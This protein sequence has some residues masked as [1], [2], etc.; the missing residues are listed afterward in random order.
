MKKTQLII[1]IFCI[2]AIL[3]M[4]ILLFRAHHNACD[5]K[6]SINGNISIAYINSDTLW[7]KYEFAKKYT[8]E[9]DTLEANLQ[10]TYN[11]KQVAFEK[12]Q[13]EASAKDKK[14]L[15]SANERQ[16]LSEQLARQ[17]QELM[18]LNQEFTARL[19]KKKS[20]EVFIQDTI[21]AALKRYNK[22]KK[23]TFILQYV[24]GNSVLV[25]NDSLEITNE[26][27][28]LLNKNY[29]KVKK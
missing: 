7:S 28:K 16:K 20:E 14:G 6:K 1:N 5:A 11:Q 10:A 19:T 17:S 29:E 26:I 13:S 8:S 15:L 4:A 9:L 25:A 2:S 12:L 27:V 21:L 22:E 24:K 23:Y 18:A 3:V